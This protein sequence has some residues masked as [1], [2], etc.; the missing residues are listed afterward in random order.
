MFLGPQG[1]CESRAERVK[2]LGMQ[3]FIRHRR[4]MI[5]LMR[6][7]G[8]AGFRDAPLQAPRMN[9]HGSGRCDDHAG[10]SRAGASGG[11]WNAIFA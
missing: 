11:R 8:R 6:A 2:T 9:F 3:R 4:M 10:V 5:A 1:W 7:E